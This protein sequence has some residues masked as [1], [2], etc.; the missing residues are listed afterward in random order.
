MPA[1]EAAASN[2]PGWL[3]CLPSAVTILRIV[4]IPLFVI[5][6]A[7]NADEPDAMAP[8]RLL[9]FSLLLAMGVS[10]IVDGWIARR[11]DL[12]TPTGALLDAV[13]DKLAQVTLL[14]FFA[15]IGKT[16]YAQVPLWFFLLVV[17]RDL[18]LLL[19][20]LAIRVKRGRVDSE[21]EPHGKV[22]SLVV[23]TLFVWLVLGGS[24]QVVDIGCIGI[25]LLVLLSTRGYVMAGWRQYR[26]G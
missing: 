19:G 26:G 1:T 5:V 25:A 20:W 8:G 16:A 7:A 24:Q 10:D 21:H 17:A 9:A 11:F 2:R 12:V 23:F 4:L 3:R 13:A 14:A 15:L 22:A 6:A 18:I